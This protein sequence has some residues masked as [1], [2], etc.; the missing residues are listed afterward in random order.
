[1]A[2]QAGL[3]GSSLYPRIRRAADFVVAYGP[4]FGS[5][6]W[7]E[8]SG[9]SPSTIAA[10]IAGLVAAA[11]IAD[12]HGDRAAARVYR[13]TADHFQ[14]SVKGWTV[15][16]TGP[17]AQRYFIR[18]AKTGDPDAVIE[19]NLGNGGPTADQRAVVDQGF[20]ELTRLGILPADDPDVRT[21]LAVVDHV[22]RRGDG[23]YRY[24]T[25]TPGTEDGY[26]DC[27]EPDPT[28]CS[29]TGA[30]WTHGNVGSGHLWPVLSG[31]RAEHQLQ[32]GDRSGAAGLLRAML[33]SSS[34]VGLVPEQSWEDPD[35]PR[36][37]YGTPAETASIGFTTGGAAG[38][39]SP[40]TWA[41]SQQVRLILSLGARRPVEQPGIVRARYV[42]RRTPA[43]LPVT[44]TAPADGAV[45]PGG[46]ATITGRTTP[47]ARV[48][49]A[50]TPT[51]VAAPT[52]TVTTTAGRT[53]TFRATVAVGF[54]TNVVTVAAEKGNGTGYARRTVISEALPGPVLLD[55]ADPSG[56]DHGPGTYAYP[57]AADFRPGAYDIEQFQVIDAGDTV[58]LRTRLRDL[59][60]T[61]GSALGAQL[62][63]VFIRDPAAPAFSPAAPFPQ[64]NYTVAADSA[65]SSRVEVQGFAGP[66]FV[67]PAGNAVGAVTVTANQATRSILIAL[68][69]ASLGMP[70]AGWVFTVALHGQ[71]GF[72]AD[73]ARTF[74]AT[75]QPYQFGLCAAGATS[76][77]CG[78]DPGAAPK[79]MDTITPADVVQE[80]ELDPTAGAVQLHGAPM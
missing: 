12:R 60:P 75:P 71:D 39:A 24:G 5:E 47:G 57:T 50:G 15:T 63:D 59:S 27:F 43:A 62:L 79:V 40:L 6:R 76:L 80:Q 42:D 74:A 69:K 21:S 65:W 14:R 13:A 30:P 49:V 11:A 78:T 26:G 53:G 44:I 35:L 67:D 64:R 37:P 55:V 70:R 66:V 46:T 23:F 56:D 10:Q 28:T 17:Y 73:Q 8:Q 31:E 68:P 20:L 41:Q 72:N 2:Y 38:S 3:G 77:I 16:T 54:L 34:G 45:V 1:M 9:H 48:T 4:S 36:S 58:F 18:L 29:P 33:A 25:I 19:Y 7:E 32:T 51:D 61:F 52:S 22:L